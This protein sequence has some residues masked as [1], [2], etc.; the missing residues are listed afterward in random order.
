[1]VKLKIEKIGDEYVFSIFDNGTGISD[2]NLDFIFN[3]G[4]STKYNKETGSICRGIGL[5]LV[6]DLVQDI[7]KGSISVQSI[8]NKNTTFTVK[9]PIS[10][11]RR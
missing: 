10:S 2:S 4:F 8:K 9:I 3:P 11:F 6:R 5:T 1:M 7:F